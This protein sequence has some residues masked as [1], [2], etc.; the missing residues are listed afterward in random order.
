ME[1][2]LK[3]RLPDPAN[4]WRP[5][6]LVLLGIT[7]PAVLIAVVGVV[8]LA[9][10]RSS[11]DIVYGVLILSFVAALATGIVLTLFS[12]KRRADI[13][14]LQTAF[15]SKV[16]HELRTP[17]TS[18]RMFVETL[19]LDRVVDPERRQECLDVLT[20]ETERLT[21]MIDRLLD[22]ARMESGR[23]HFE[24]VPCP[25]ASVV[26][27]ALSAFKPQRL[28]GQI[29]LEVEVPDGLPDLLADEE[30]LADVLLNLLNN[31]YKY[32]GERKHIRLAARPD[33]PRVAISV[34]DDGP[35]IPHS[36]RFHIFE[37]FYRGSH[38]RIESI[39]GTGL[40]LAMARHVV[41]AHRGTIEVESELGQGST[42]TVAIPVA[43][44]SS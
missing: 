24:L 15:V 3:G 4:F 37:R 9:S 32:S 43:P 7:L 36:E 31:A 26:G 38:P 8:V 20:V 42:F 40:G 10:S 35:G 39:E 29:E 1:V 30:A 2:S 5:A 25:V 14:A 13:S 28:S 27:R 44:A 23:R 21:A 17:L 33:G 19:K 16:S 18:I 11:L 41:H 22:W 6:L 12:I 34:T